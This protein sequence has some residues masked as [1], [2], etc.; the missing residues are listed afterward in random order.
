MRARAESFG[1][2]VRLDEPPALVAV[3]RELARRLGVEGGDAWAEGEARGPSAPLEV[4]VAVTS[5]CGGGC[6][7]CYLDATPEGHAPDEGV[8][9]ARLEDLS[10]AGVFTVAFGGGEPL[11]RPDLGRLAARAKALGLSPVLTTSGLGMTPRRAESLRAFDQVNVSHDG[12]GGA[13]AEVRGWA[14]G[15]VAEAAMSMLRAAGV[16]FGVNVVLTRQSF[17]AVEATVARAADLGAVEAQ[18]LRFKPAGRA[19]GLAYLDARLTLAQRREVVPL[20]DRL[21]RSRRLAVRID[22][23]LV[24]FFSAHAGPLSDGA[25]LARGGVFGCEAGRHLGALSVDGGLAPCSFIAPQ[26]RGDGAPGDHV[27]AWRDDALARFR[28]HADEPPWP[29]A[30]CS[31]RVACRGGCRA[32]AAHEGDPWGPDPECPRVVELSPEGRP[33]GAT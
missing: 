30:T 26:A 10:R 28:E 23:A 14:G 16:R 3:D 4:H 12:V 32:V 20:L 33:R 5:R 24:P 22:C 21:A 18:L 25:A 13:Y 11:S 8:I 1:A 31:L 9:V 6:K 17:S 27:A 15:D 2:W 29:C 19:V 7:G